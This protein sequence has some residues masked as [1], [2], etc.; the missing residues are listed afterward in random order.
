ML[1]RMLRCVAAAPLLAVTAACS[2][3]SSLPEPVVFTPVG[4]TP[5]TVHDPAFEPRPAADA[6]F[7]ELNGGK[8]RIEIPH[9]WNGGLVMF[10]RGG[11]EFAESF[12]VQIPPMDSWLIE[13]GYAWAATSYDRQDYIT[14]A[15]ADQTAAFW[16]YTASEFGRPDRTYAM[17]IS[18]G[19]AAALISAERY[20]DR[21]V[22]ALAVCGVSGAQSY[23][24]MFADFMAAAVYAAGMPH[25]EFFSRQPGESIFDHLIPLLEADPE[26]RRLFEAIWMSLSGGPRTYGVEGFRMR[27]DALWARSAD[28]ARVYSNIDKE[29]MLHDW[30]GVQSDEFNQAA[31]RFS[32]TDA[33]AAIPP[34]EEITGEIEIPVVIL[35]TTGDG[36]VPLS[37]VQYVERKVA[38]AG[39]S[40]L[41]DV[42][43]VEDGVHCGFTTNEYIEA[44]ELLVEE[45]ERSASG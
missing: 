11:Y 15:A 8:Y 37:Q 30:T 31:I 1:A 5:I 45:V 33:R 34:T 23:W 28:M 29:Y 14:G 24:D 22:G 38:E 9:D 3:G 26:Q 16:D 2:E 13:N 41:L 12:D 40:H 6:Y 43:L 32:G 21:Y 27:E 19:G 39:R 44:F 36:L 25:D 18:M 10:M 42:R 7:G 35:H 17:G 4:G 20:S